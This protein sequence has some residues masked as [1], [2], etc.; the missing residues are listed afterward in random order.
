MNLTLPC[1]DH[2]TNTWQLFRFVISVRLYRGR[3]RNTERRRDTETERR[4]DKETER[5]RETERRRDR[6]TE[7]QRDREAGETERQRAMR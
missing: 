1:A 5:Q 2:E 4:R 3:D 6:E 7:R